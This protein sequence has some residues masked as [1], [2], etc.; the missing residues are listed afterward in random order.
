MR[1]MTRTLLLLAALL[2]HACSSLH[3]STSCGLSPADRQQA[4]TSIQATLKEIN[5]IRPE[6]YLNDKFTT[7]GE[8]DSR[9]YCSFL[10]KPWQPIVSEFLWDGTLAFRVSKKTLQV[11]DY[12]RVDE[13]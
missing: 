3:S 5:F 12:F 7:H 4:L 2:T 9:E 10:V 6:Q 11:E 1:A 13:G 8:F